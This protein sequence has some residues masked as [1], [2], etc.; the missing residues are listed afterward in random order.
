MLPA[1][2]IFLFTLTLVI[3]QPKGLGVGW[4]AS[5]GAMLALLFGVVTL[6]CCAA[7]A[8]SNQTTL[9]AIPRYNLPLLYP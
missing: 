2:L 9:S 6:G 4:S 7:P 5:L 3:W 8:I 1:A